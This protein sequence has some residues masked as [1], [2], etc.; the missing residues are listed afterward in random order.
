MAT[1]FVVRHGNTFDKGDI[2]TRVG[3]RT[4]LPLSSSGTEQAGTLGRHF[5]DKGLRF[6]TAYCSTLR[7]AQKTAEIILRCTESG[8]GLSP[9]PFLTEVDYGPDENKPEPDVIARIG[10]HALS[11]W[12]REA[13]PPA[14]WIVDIEGIIKGWTDLFARASSLPPDVNVLAVTSNGVA[15]FITRVPGFRN[16]YPID[17]LKLRTAAYARLMCTPSATELTQWDLR[18]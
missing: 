5:R 3:G 7:R 1:V 17:S 15:R 18:P 12:E 4:D 2:V 13:V 10:E 9:Q 6:D 14:G 8:V 11:V 16:S